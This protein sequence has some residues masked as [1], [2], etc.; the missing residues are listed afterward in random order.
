MGKNTENT[1]YVII[2]L[3]VVGF[4]QNWVGMFFSMIPMQCSSQNL[5][6]E[7]FGHFIGG[8]DPPV[9]IGGVLDRTF[10]GMI[11]HDP[12]KDFS[13]F[14]F[15]KKGKGKRRTYP[16]GFLIF[17]FKIAQNSSFRKVAVQHP[18]PIDT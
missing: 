7:K 15:H 4:S 6:F 10:V 5:K 16:K 11:G 1:F 2:S 12:K 13:I 14:L 9:S 3:Q 17:F 8:S 18:P